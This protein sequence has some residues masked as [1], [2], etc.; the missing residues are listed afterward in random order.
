MMYCCGI[1]YRL[2]RSRNMKK[3][4]IAAGFMSSFVVACLIASAEQPPEGK[5]PPEGRK[6]RQSGMKEKAGP[7]RFEPGRLI[8]RPLR[9][10]LHLSDDQISQ[11]DALEK[12]VKER[13]LKILNEEQKKQLVELAQRP[14]RGGSD[15]KGK[16]PPPSDDDRSR[17]KNRKKGPPLDDRKSRDEK[18]GPPPPSPDDDQNHAGIQ[19]F[20][21]LERGLQ[22][23]QR[24]GRPILF[25]AATPH[26]GGISGIW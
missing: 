23:A 10:E 20:G 7:P 18:K 14:P 25:L 2:N 12:D 8:P 15:D 13:L 24:T 16:G 1:G 4:L 19:W 5:G 9:E 26:C 3:S 17:G 11:L 6:S 21:T 22:E